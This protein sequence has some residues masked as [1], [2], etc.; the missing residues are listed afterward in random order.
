MTDK[1]IFTEKKRLSNHIRIKTERLVAR[2]ESGF[3]EFDMD[4]GCLCAICST[5]LKS[6]FNIHGYDAEVYI[7]W[8]R[9]DSNHCWVED[10]EHIWD[11]TATQFGIKRKTVCLKKDSLL[12]KQW[13]IRGEQVDGLDGM[14]CEKIEV[15]DDWSEEQKPNKDIV[16]KLVT[17]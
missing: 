16:L 15:F 14:A 17:A 5:A 10:G 8:F 11:V 9:G 4:L 6:I 7:G 12:A 1:E 13:Y 3:D 2:E